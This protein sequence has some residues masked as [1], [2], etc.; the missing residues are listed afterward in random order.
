MTSQMQRHRRMSPTTKYTIEELKQ[1]CINDY[2]KLCY[3][4]G[5]TQAD[6]TSLENYKKQVAIMDL[7]QLV[8][9]SWYCEGMDGCSLDEYI[10]CFLPQTQYKDMRYEVNPDGSTILQAS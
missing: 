10:E 6:E 1:A 7:A 8:D 9:E 3:D 2:A 5:G 4:D